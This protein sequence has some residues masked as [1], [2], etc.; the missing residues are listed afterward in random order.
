MDNEL[1]ECLIKLVIED[2]GRTNIYN[3]LDHLLLMLDDEELDY[4]LEQCDEDLFLN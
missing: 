1:V 2:T 4:F 3:H